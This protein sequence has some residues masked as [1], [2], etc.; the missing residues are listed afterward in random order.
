MGGAIALPNFEIFLKMYKRVFT[1]QKVDDLNYTRT[2]NTPNL[3]NPL[4]QLAHTPLTE[5][6]ENS[7]RTTKY[8]M[9]VLML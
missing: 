6:N 4:P 1:V 3:P 5:V 2:S 8:Q 7:I 9:A